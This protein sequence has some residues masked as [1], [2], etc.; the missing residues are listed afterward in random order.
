MDQEEA[1]TTKPDVPSD[2]DQDQKTPQKLVGSILLI[3]DDLPMIKMYSTKLKVE[4]FEVKVAYD[5]EEGLK[6]IKEQKP[7]LILLD[8]MIPKLGGMEI[9]EEIKTSEALKKIPV[10]IL[11]N[12]SQEQDIKRSKELGVGHFLVKSNYTPSQVVRIVKS[13][14]TGGETPV[15]EETAKETKDETMDANS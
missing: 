1:K 9:L 12:L 15:K 4:G 3:E 10:V 13:Y 6:K 5:G 11:S 2:Q 8:L 14:F 7:D